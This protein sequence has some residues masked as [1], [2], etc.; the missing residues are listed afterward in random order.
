MKRLVMIL[1]C[2]SQ[3]FLVGCDLESLNGEKADE[4]NIEQEDGGTADNSGDDEEQS[5]NEYLQSIQK[6]KGLDVSD[7][8]ATGKAFAVDILTEDFKRL[9]NLYIYDEEMKKIISLDETRKEIIFHNVDLGEVEKIN[10]AY[11]YN[12]GANR[13]VMVPVEASMYNFNLL[14][15]FNHDNEIIGF[16]YE[17]HKGNS[18]DKLREIPGGITEEEFSFVSDEYIIN[19]TLTTPDYKADGELLGSYPLVI[20]VHGFGPSDRDSSIFENKPFQDIAW[21]LGQAGI[22][23]YRYDKRTYLYEDGT[24]NPSFTVYE[25]TI[26]DVISATN[27]AKELKN[28]DENRVYI[29]GASHG[30]YLLPRIA[31]NIPEA[32]GYILVSSPAQHMKDY[33]QEQYEYLAMEDGNISIEEHTA[34]NDIVSDLSS[35]DMPNE[36]PADERVLGFYR[37]YWLDLNRYNLIQE[38]SRITNPVLLL[39]GERDYQTTT[40]QYNIWMDTF[41]EVENWTFK[42]Y[43][44]LNH[45]MMEG[46][47]NSYSSEYREKG[48]VDEQVIQDIANFIFTN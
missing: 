23:S 25:E 28:V 1:I 18:S 26:N 4:N 30:G 41:Y 13:F 12:Y 36:I 33:L 10:E 34:I 9:E 43:P 39:Q 11:T 35:L 38:A 45:F 5:D 27:M 32:A 47:G 21:G 7:I 42:S 29:L 44:K 31:G 14:I 48:Y 6:A 3:I 24:N 40:R 19:G 22:A 37:N 46:E 17:E 16:S 2:V 20:L 15:S 8:L